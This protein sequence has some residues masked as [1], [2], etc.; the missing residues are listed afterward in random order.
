MC[1]LALIP[2]RPLVYAAS[3]YADTIRNV[4]TSTASSADKFKAIES[5]RSDSMDLAIKSSYNE[6][7]SKAESSTAS[8]WYDSHV[9]NLNPK[10][11]G[12][13]AV[14]SIINDKYK[15]IMCTIPK[16]DSST[17]RRLMLY[18][19]RPD[20]VR[21]RTFSGP[22][23]LMSLEQRLQ[24]PHNIKKNG[25]KI[26]AHQS[27]S[28][29]TRYYNDATYIK[30]FLCRNPVTRLLSAWLSKN[31]NSTNPLEFASNFPTFE[32]FVNV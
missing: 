30:V 21:N 7:F 15:I 4:L 25:V 14:S 3:A 1:P 11:N 9:V 32:L 29:A 16:I 22:G 31:S 12:I 28:N 6:L 10:R 20:V 26:M 2:H 24:D 19:E 27:P 5:I 8:V 23:K 13:A 17:W 18:L